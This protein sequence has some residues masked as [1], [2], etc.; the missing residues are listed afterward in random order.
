MSEKKAYF[1]LIDHMRTWLFELPDSEILMPMLEVRFSPEEAAFL[2][3]FPNMPHTLEE[4]SRRLGLSPE[5]LTQK[6]D[7][8]IRKGMIY[9]VEGR[10]AVRYTFT[11]VIFFFSRM[12]G[13]KGEKDEWNRRVAPLFNRYYI[14]HLGDDFM[15]HPT[16][17]LRAIPIARTIEDTRQVMPYEDVVQFV[18]RE[19]YL[20]VSTCACRHRHNLDPNLPTCKHETETCLHFGKLGRYIVR[21]DMGREI[22]REETM[23][24]LA[25]AAD[26]G[27]VHGISNTREG[28]DTICNCCS[29]CCLFLESVNMPAPVPRGHQPS[30]YICTIN[31]LTCKGCGLCT[32][33]CPMGALSLVASEETDNKAGKVSALDPER[34]IGCG[35]CVHK[36]P[37]QSLVLV[38]REEEQDYPRDMGEAGRRMLEERGRDISMVF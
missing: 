4:L 35:V 28:M 18:E 27:L 24:I 29:C 22:T 8:M 3:K 37:T 19:D 9:R 5:A 25:N 7:P 17:G 34:C 33:R 15:G 12:P 23:E 11:D 14:D 32:E 30:N 2:S 36:C 10:N 31:P 26:A 6:M 20:T 13:W 38:R 1:D 16:K 21:H